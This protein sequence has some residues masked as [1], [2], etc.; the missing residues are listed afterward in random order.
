MNYKILSRKWSKSVTAAHKIRSKGIKS[1][2]AT[3]GSPS[4]VQHL[5]PLSEI[6]LAAADANAG[7]P[8][9]F[10]CEPD[11]GIDQGEFH[12]RPR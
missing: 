1:S 2:K 8:C 5:N 9:D 4:S 3:G 7:L 11:N 12:L 10:D 6:V